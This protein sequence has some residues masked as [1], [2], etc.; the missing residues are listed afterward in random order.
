MWITDGQLLATSQAKISHSTGKEGAISCQEY[1]EVGSHGHR[2]S[3]VGRLTSLAPNSSRALLYHYRGV[4]KKA[5]DLN[6]V[7]LSR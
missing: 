1:T 2:T 6:Q 5:T 4:V 7:G 3:G